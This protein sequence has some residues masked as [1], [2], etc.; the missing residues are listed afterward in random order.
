MSA[1]LKYS[2]KRRSMVKEK[3]PDMSNTDVSRLLGEMWRSASLSERAPY[4]E[5]EEV[6]RAQY[7][8]EIKNWREEQVKLDAASRTSH[9][10]V[11]HA[12]EKQPP[13]PKKRRDYDHGAFIEH[14]S[15]SYAHASL[16]V[17]T[18]DGVVDRRIFRSYSGSGHPVEHKP[19]KG[20]HHRAFRPS[21]P[22]A[23]IARAHPIKS[24]TNMFRPHKPVDAR[25]YKPVPSDSSSAV[26]PS[27]MQPSHLP[28]HHPQVY[29]AP[30][31]QAQLQHQGENPH[32]APLRNTGS[33]IS[34]F[35][36]FYDPEPPF[37]PSQRRPSASH[38][39]PDSF[40]QY[41]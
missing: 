39:F 10:S 37:N 23:E 21:Y 28:R 7:K 38:Y 31:G 33:D 25:S 27:M 40:Y 12:A 22:H 11:Q 17:P 35:D 1:F 29:R 26:G 4:V 3:N 36:A 34:Q 32:L 18:V 9:H 20:D 16:R 2:Q 15:G 6:E 13:P 41:P 5:Q 19:Y 8:E 30:Y 24:E 14:P